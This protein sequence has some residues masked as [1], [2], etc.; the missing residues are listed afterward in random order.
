MGERLQAWLMGFVLI[1]YSIQ[2]VTSVTVKE[3]L[4]VSHFTILRRKSANH[5]VELVYLIA[6][7]ALTQRLAL[8]ATDPSFH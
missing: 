1:A 6:L 8:S 5:A 4:H 3:R 7:S 2:I